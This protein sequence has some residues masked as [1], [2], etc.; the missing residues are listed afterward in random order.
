[1]KLSD[2]FSVWLRG[3][4]SFYTGTLKT[5]T[6]QAGTT[7]SDT[8]QQFAIDLEPQIVFT[9]IQHLG[10]TAALNID[11]APSFLGNYSHQDSVLGTTTGT[12]DVVYAGVTLGMIA[13]F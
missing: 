13:Y 3:G 1:M 2:L 4:P 6:P 5:G 12:A 7:Q 8:Q 9:P 10:F 11:I